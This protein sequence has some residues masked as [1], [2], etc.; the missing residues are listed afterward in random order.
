MKTC[1]YCAKTVY[2]LAG[3]GL[4]AACYYRNKRNGTPDRVKVRK[5]CTID[6]CDRLQVAKGMCELHYR[7]MKRHGVVQSERLDRW[8]HRNAH[9]LY[10]SWK[11]F[12]RTRALSEEWKDFWQFVRDVGDRPS[13]VHRICRKDISLPAGPSN[14]YWREPLTDIPTNTKAGRALYQRVY[15][16]NNPERVKNAELKKTHGISLSL[17]NAKLEYQ[18]GVCAICRK[19]ETALD[20]NGQ[21]RRLSV[22]HCHNHGHIRGL[23]CTA[24]NRGLGLFQ[25]DAERLIRAAKY[26]CSHD[27]E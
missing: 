18:K 21:I 17:Y 13:P 25:D 19:P 15:R 24:C 12:S 6:G 20:K 23:L 4:C 3:G 7:R 2:R 26:I 9:P 27:P 1:S 16:L 8:G 22:D 10:E 5:T 11:H 14:Y